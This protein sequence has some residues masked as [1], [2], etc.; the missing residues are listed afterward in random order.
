M[1][2]ENKL[3][4][5]MLFFGSEVPARGDL[6]SRGA[7]VLA[8]TNLQYGAAVEGRR[9]ADLGLL[10]WDQDCHSYS[11]NSNGILFMLDSVGVSQFG[12]FTYNRLRNFPLF[13]IFLL[14]GVKLIVSI[15]L[16]KRL[17]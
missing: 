10:L 12:T 8:Q 1:W 4:E 6:D 2:K 13:S 14:N 7:A 15:R 9:C 17:K 16:K 3:G 11:T 5:C